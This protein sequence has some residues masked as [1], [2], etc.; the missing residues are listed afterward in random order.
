[1]ALDPVSDDADPGHTPVEHDPGEEVVLDGAALDPAQADP[2]IDVVDPVGPA[3]DLHI[4]HGHVRDSV[5]EDPGRSRILPVPAEAIAAPVDRHAR[6][7]HLDADHVV[8][9]HQV[10]GEIVVAGRRDHSRARDRKR[11]LGR[12]GFRRHRGALREVG[13]DR[14][15]EPVRDL[16]LPRLIGMDVPGPLVVRLPVE[17]RVEVDHDDPRSRG[18]TGRSPRRQLVVELDQ[19]RVDVP[20]TVAGGRQLR[21]DDRDPGVL[22][23]EGVH[24]TV[25]VREAGRHRRL[26]KDVVRADQHEGHVGA[27]PRE[28]GRELPPG[29]DAVQDPPDRVTPVPFVVLVEADRE[30]RHVPGADEVDVVAVRPELVPEPVPVGRVHPAVVRVEHALRQRVAERDDPGRGVHGP[31]EQEQEDE[32]D[33]EQPQGAPDGGPAGHRTITTRTLLPP[34]G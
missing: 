6:R 34:A 33:Q 26:G 29:A 13:R 3:R 28:P 18:R 20:I 21:E 22:R 4:L 8:P 10:A 9:V 27:V 17:A 15:V 11:V 5:D 25:Q 1:M 16:L 23:P 32:R 31:H 19:A 14:R 7:H 30:V 2:W 24:D 12:G